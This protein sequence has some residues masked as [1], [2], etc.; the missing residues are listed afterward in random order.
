MTSQ[1]T[2]SAHDLNTAA[3]LLERINDALG[4]V[5]TGNLSKDTASALVHRRPTIAALVSVYRQAARETAAAHLADGP[6]DD[7]QDD[8]LDYLHRA[9][10]RGEA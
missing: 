6:A 10:E 9:I 7:V 4:P 5:N 1:H 8:D 2:A 3:D